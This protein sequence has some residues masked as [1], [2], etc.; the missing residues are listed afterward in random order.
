[1]SRAG[2]APGDALARNLFDFA[3]EKLAYYKPPGWIAF[4]D[5]LP[6]TSTQN[7]NR[8]GVR[9]PIGDAKLLMYRAVEGA[10]LEA[11]SQSAFAICEFRAGNRSSNP[12]CAIYGTVR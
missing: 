6:K 1:V 9:R 12:D 4:V 8:R 2:F 10:L 11:Y 5:R 7:V 3:N